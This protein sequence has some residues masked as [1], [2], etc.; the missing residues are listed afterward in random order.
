MDSTKGIYN[1]LRNLRKSST[2]MFFSVHRHNKVESSDGASVADQDRILQ[3]FLADV[4]V[5][6]EFKDKLVKCSKRK[7][8]I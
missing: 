6:L 7:C 8:C 3:N 1:F 2:S 4:F 5:R